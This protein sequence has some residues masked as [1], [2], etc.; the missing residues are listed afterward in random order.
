MKPEKKTIGSPDCDMRLF[1]HRNEKGLFLNA[2]TDN[3]GEKD[4]RLPDEWFPQVLVGEAC[5]VGV[6]DMETECCFVKDKIEKVTFKTDKNENTHIVSPV[7]IPK[8]VIGKNREFSGSKYTMILC[9]CALEFETYRESSNE[10]CLCVTKE[11]DYIGVNIVKF[12]DF[13]HG[14]ESPLLNKFRKDILRRIE[15][16][17]GGIETEVK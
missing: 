13:T 14:I 9:N 5:R 15:S 3:T 1:V 10:C 7:V 6:Y 17:C 2:S 4:I 16:R 11:E 12:V 8:I